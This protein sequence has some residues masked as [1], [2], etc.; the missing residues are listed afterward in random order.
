MADTL[1]NNNPKP[2]VILQNKPSFFQNLKSLLISRKA[3]II[4]ISLI[5]VSIVAAAIITRNVL[6]NLPSSTAPQPAVQTTTPTQIAKPAVSAI[7]TAVCNIDKANNPLVYEVKDVL[8]SLRQIDLKGYVKQVNLD[9]AK[10][11]AS[12]TLN[13][14]NGQQS[15]EFAVEN[16]L[17][18]V[19]SGSKTLKP[20]DLKPLD[21]VLAAFNC[22]PKINSEWT[23]SRMN[24]SKP[25]K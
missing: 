24:L 5:L 16:I 20:S 13:S 22:N 14:I 18:Q 7:L 19:Y 25:Q 15:Y 1:E 12:I 2:T 6:I 17:E 21:N 10:N 11:I 8:P 3:L 23:F 4:L 9:K